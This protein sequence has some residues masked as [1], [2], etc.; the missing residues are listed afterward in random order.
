M[1]EVPADD[2]SLLGGCDANFSTRDR[3]KHVTQL[4]S[5][6]ASKNRPRQERFLSNKKGTV[7]D[8]FAFFNPRF[9]SGNEPCGN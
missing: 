3:W 4:L 5:N 7:L 8:G 9:K 1:Q 6:K 2:A